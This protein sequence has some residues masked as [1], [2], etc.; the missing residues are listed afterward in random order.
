[1]NAKQQNSHRD[2]MTL[3]EIIMAILVLAILAVCGATAAHMS[4]RTVIIQRNRREAI[5]VAHRML[6]TLRATRYSSL[7]PSTLDYTPYYGLTNSAG[8]VVLQTL[9][10][11]ETVSIGGIDVPIETRVQYVDI[12]GGEV[13]FDGLILDVSVGYHSDPNDRVALQTFYANDGEP[14]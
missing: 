1:M 9:D 10:P 6:E 8:A 5:G 11:H 4:R 3:V 14:E 2:G 13:S 12:D 7:A